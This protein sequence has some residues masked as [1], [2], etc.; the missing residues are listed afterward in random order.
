MLEAKAKQYPEAELLTNMSK[1]QICLC[2]WDY[3]F[4]CNENENQNGKMDHM[5]KT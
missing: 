5:N 2:Q 3:I 4:N 1:R